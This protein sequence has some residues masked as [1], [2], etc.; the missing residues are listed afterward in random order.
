MDTHTPVDTRRSVNDRVIYLQ[1]TLKLIP[2]SPAKVAAKELLN[3]LDLSLIDLG[4]AFL[5][6]SADDPLDLLYHLEKDVRR[7]RLKLQ[8]WADAT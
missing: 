1:G 4:V 6:T 8:A 3:L 5:S 2:D 7:L